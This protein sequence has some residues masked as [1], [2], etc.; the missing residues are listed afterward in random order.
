VLAF[1][2]SIVDKSA[3]KMESVMPQGASMGTTTTIFSHNGFF[4]LTEPDIFGENKNESKSLTSAGAVAPKTSQT[5]SSEEI[6]EHIFS[7]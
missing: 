6:G 2:E 5:Q 7:F 3:A 4:K 1:L